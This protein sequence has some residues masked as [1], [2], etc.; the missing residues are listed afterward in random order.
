MF[1]FCSA[2]KNRTPPCNLCTY[3]RVCLPAGPTINSVRRRPPGRMCCEVWFSV[4]QCVLLR[5]KGVPLHYFFRVVS[6]DNSQYRIRIRVVYCLPQ[7]VIPWL[8]VYVYKDGGEL[9]VCFAIY[10]SMCFSSRRVNERTR[11]RHQ[12][13]IKRGRQTERKHKKVIGCR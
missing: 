4:F 1:T 12:A 3:V 11:T 13:R 5:S 8:L 7:S 2:S 6:N 10:F 9:R